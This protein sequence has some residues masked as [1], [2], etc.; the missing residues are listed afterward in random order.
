MVFTTR[1]QVYAQRFAVQALGRGE[2]PPCLRQA[3]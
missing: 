3:R 1:E 2:V